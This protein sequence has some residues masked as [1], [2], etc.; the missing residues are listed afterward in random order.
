MKHISKAT[1][2]LE[3]KSK[4]SAIGLSPKRLVLVVLAFSVPAKI[5]SLG[6]FKAANG[7]LITRMSGPLMAQL[8]LYCFAPTAVMRHTSPIS[9]RCAG[10][11]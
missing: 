7:V 6:T 9:F 4:L 3:F 8:V 1:G 10:L 2:M 5:H 11:L